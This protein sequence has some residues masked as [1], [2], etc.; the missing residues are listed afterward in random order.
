MV[1][2]CDCHVLIKLLHYCPDAIRNKERK[3]IKPCK[4]APM[5]QERYDSSQ[6]CGRA[7]C[8]LYTRIRNGWRCCFYNHV[9]KD[10]DVICK[11]R[12][13][14]EHEHENQNGDGEHER[15]VHERRCCHMIC[16]RCRGLNDKGHGFMNTSGDECE[17]SCCEEGSGDDE[18]E[19]EGEGSSSTSVP[20]STASTEVNGEG[21]GSP[22]WF[23]Q[24]LQRVLEA[25]RR[26]MVESDNGSEYSGSVGRFIFPSVCLLWCGC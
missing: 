26:R 4:W 7:Q 15:S 18:D 16:P 20:S 10:G 8:K 21:F 6:V 23:S 12:V 25:R 5:H 1:Y 13:L 14:C 3:T 17:G 2:R 11:G 19:C 22:H 9:N 24:G